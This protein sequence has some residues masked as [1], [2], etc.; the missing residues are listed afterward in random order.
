MVGGLPPDSVDDFDGLTKTFLTQFLVGRK[1]KRTLRYLLTLRQGDIK[2]LKDYLDR[3]N[4]ERLTMEDMSKNFILTAILNELSPKGSFVPELAKRTLTTL[5]E[6][7]DKAEE[8]ASYEETMK[9]YAERG[10]SPRTQARRRSPRRARSCEPMEGC[11]RLEEELE[12]A[13]EAQFA[14]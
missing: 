13:G 14:S 2:S 11:R 1:C 12:A 7:M 9:A 6:F 10:R 8:F 5:Q 3:F 4:Q